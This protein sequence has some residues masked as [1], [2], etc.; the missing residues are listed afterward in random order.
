MQEPPK[1]FIFTEFTTD[2]IKG[3]F[4]D[5]NQTF[6]PREDH[7]YDS[8]RQLVN[9]AGYLIDKNENIVDRY[10]CLVFSIEILMEK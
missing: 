8:K 4:K 2:W 6:D 7:L 10:G 9:T 5:G 1:I 3:T